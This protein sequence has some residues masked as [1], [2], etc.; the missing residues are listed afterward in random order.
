MKGSIARSNLLPTLIL[1]LRQQ[2]IAKRYHLVTMVFFVIPFVCISFLP[3]HYN[4]GVS[5]DSSYY[6]IAAQNLSLN[7][8]FINYYGDFINIFPPVY[9]ALLATFSKMSGVDIPGTG[10]FIN[11]IF[12]SLLFFVFN[13]V[14]RTAKTGIRT[15]IALNLILLF[16]PAMQVFSM[17]WSEVPFIVILLSIFF[18]ILRNNKPAYSWGQLILIG[19]LTGA[20][21][22]TRF[23]ALPFIVLLM[24]YF[25]FRQ[26]ATWKRKV[27]DLLIFLL[28]LVLIYCCWHFYKS[29]FPPAFQRRE[30]SVHLVS[31]NHLK[32]LLHTVYS[33]VSPFNL[34]NT[35]I[36]FV[37]AGLLLLKYK[38]AK[39]ISQVLSYSLQNRLVIFS[40][41][42]IFVYVS[43]IIF[44]VS[45]IDATVPLDNRI[46]FPVFPFALFTLHPILA[47]LLDGKL[48]LQRISIVLLLVILLAGHV[49]NTIAY[50]RDTSDHGQWYTSRD[51]KNSSAIQALNKY[52]G[53]KIY[54]NG[55]DVAAFYS[56]QMQGIDSLPLIYSSVSKE[57]NKK[58]DVQM[59]ELKHT[60]TKDPAI[61]LFF[62]NIEYR[63]YYPDKTLLLNYFHDMKITR[64]KDGLIIEAIKP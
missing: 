34:L 12:C 41:S 14:L 48:N 22:M 56:N 4:L 32:Q 40:L 3:F 24:G 27:K 35:I 53:Y 15:V 58:F 21:F 52:K 11:S 1:F 7:R 9:P 25:L 59:L 62:D 10:L 43:F 6:I 31:F 55:D 37:L 44:T 36:V 47:K 16:S 2:L 50:W 26:S 5:P 61:I 23:A 46:F 17:Y 20:L 54:T 29:S 60:L 13:L 57:H 8:G 39:I 64:L 42:A 33:W 38:P 19:I 63:T 45:F 30:F 28:P 51:W 18:L 49:K